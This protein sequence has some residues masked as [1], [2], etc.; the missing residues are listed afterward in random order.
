MNS[1]T[2]ICKCKL[3]AERKLSGRNENGVTDS[4]CIVVYYLL[5]CNRRQL[6]SEKSIHEYSPLLHF[7]PTVLNSGYN[8]SASVG[9]FSVFFGLC[10]YI[11][12][13]T[14]LWLY[15]PPLHNHILFYVSVCILDAA[16]YVSPQLHFFL[17]G[18]NMYLFTLA[19][20]FS[21]WETWKAKL[22]KS[23]YVSISF[24]S[25]LILPMLCRERSY[26][27]KGESA[28]ERKSYN[29]VLLG[30]TDMWPSLWKWFWCKRCY[31]ACA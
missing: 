3:Y 17:Q 5:L 12:K 18:I 27:R 30:V 7:W 29:G 15:T 16:C 8:G 28:S 4:C 14:V 9:F 24:R 20:F 13:T 19:S 25:F 23:N 31:A 10:E 21:R 6:L 26:S 2:T 11:I 1:R 22:C